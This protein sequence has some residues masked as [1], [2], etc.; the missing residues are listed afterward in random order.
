MKSEW[1]CLKTNVL[2]ERP[3]NHLNNSETCSACGGT[4]Y[5]SDCIQFENRFKKED[6]EHV[7]AA[8]HKS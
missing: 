8:Q 5:L 3:C 6:L 7:K 2:N 4:R 1:I